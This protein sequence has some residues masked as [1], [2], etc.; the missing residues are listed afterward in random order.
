MRK[1][2]FCAILLLAIVMSSTPIYATT[3]KS[4]EVK[5]VYTTSEEILFD[6]MRPSINKFVID[7]YG[8]LV[9]WDEPRITDAK[10]IVGANNWTFEVTLWLKVYDPEDQV[11]GF[12]LDKLTLKIDSTRNSKSTISQPNIMLMEYKNIVPPQ[13]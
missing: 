8:H 12:G 2:C 11:E 3:T 4:E 1:L 13:N 9:H 7:Y 5:K 6:M 10:S